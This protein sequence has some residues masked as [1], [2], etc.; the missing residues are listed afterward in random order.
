MLKPHIFKDAFM[1]KQLT[2]IEFLTAIKN[3]EL[4]HAPMATTIPMKLIEV[5]E[6]YVV[7][8]VSPNDAHINLQGGI[9]G[10]FCA[11]ILDSVTGGAA[12]TIMDAG[13]KFATTDLSIKMIRPMQSGKT[14]KG[15]GQLI[16][17]GRTLVITEGKI[18]DDNNKIFAYATA[19]L[20]I[21]QP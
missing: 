19:T 17:A 7:Y 10:G 4:S 8:E 20:M 6:G 21:I 3:G 14:Y 5:S 2:G 15:I 11:T 9:H 18:V 12:H 13:V 16:N 1:S